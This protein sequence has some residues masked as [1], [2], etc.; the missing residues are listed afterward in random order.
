MPHAHHGA[1][2][3]HSMQRGTPSHG[4]GKMERWQSELITQ[5]NL[6]KQTTRC[7]QKQKTNEQGKWLSLRKHTV[8]KTNHL[9][10]LTSQKAK[11]SHWCAS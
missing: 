2:A 7:G 9:Q 8:T 3:P 5:P 11:K 10:A 4:I 6:P 1:R